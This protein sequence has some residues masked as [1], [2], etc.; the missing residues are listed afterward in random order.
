MR[1]RITARPAAPFGSVP[2]DSKAVMPSSSPS[3]LRVQFERPFIALQPCA[4][5]D[6]RV[7]VELT[8]R[9]GGVGEIYAVG[10]ARSPLARVGD[11]GADIGRAVAEYAPFVIAAEPECPLGHE[12]QRVAVE[13]AYEVRGRA[14]TVRV[15]VFRQ[16]GFD[17]GTCQAEAEPVIRAR[18]RGELD[19]LALRGATVGVDAEVVDDL[20]QL[21]VF[22]VEEEC[23]DVEREVTALVAGPDP[24]LVIRQLVRVVSR[25]CTG[26][27]R[28][29]VGPARPEAG[30]DAQVRRGRVAE[31][32][33][34]RER[35]GDR[36]FR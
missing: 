33:A 7:A 19:A 3:V 10:E 16:L 26:V 15:S 13:A 35:P 12:R 30:C 14:G 5:V 11:Q 18:R 31:L 2:G 22:P 36:A 20:E 32:V 21:D 29:H 8:Q 24:D 1:G 25:G 28:Q 34:W 6:G 9:G 23:G 27:R 4:Q 17:V